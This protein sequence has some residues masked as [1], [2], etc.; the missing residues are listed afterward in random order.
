M[1]DRDED[2]ELYRLAVDEYRFQVNLNWQRSQY[3]LGLNVAVLT[4]AVGILR[5]GDEPSIGVRLL[6]AAV[7]IVGIAASVVSVLA[8]Q[9]QRLYYQTARDRMMAIGESLQ[10]GDRAVATTP[11]MGSSTR[12]FSRVTT[13][14]SALFAVVAIIDAAALVYVL[15]RDPLPLA[16][17]TA[18]VLCAVALAVQMSRSTLTKVSVLLSLAASLVC[19]AGAG[20][21]ASRS[22]QRGVVSVE[23]DACSPPAAA[24]GVV[25]NDSDETRSAIVEVHFLVDDIRT[26]VATAAV[27]DIAPHERARWVASAGGTPATPQPRCDVF[28]RTP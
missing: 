24:T 20:I 28:I 23:V 5:V 15:R 1:S 6:T 25:Q 22:E 13:L 21:A 3:F 12:R 16:F 11:G 27:D 14:L 9:T 10:L 17:V 19:A 26:A 2:R 7:F 4:V 18:V 8:H